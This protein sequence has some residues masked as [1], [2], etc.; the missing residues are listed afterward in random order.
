M[1][2]PI[3]QVDAF[4]EQAFEG[5][6]AAVVLL[7][8][9]AGAAWMQAVAAEMNLSETAFVLPEGPMP[10]SLRWF[11]PAAEV[12]LCGHATLATA[13]MLYE[14]GRIEQDETLRFDSVSGELRARRLSDGRIELDFPQTPAAPC[15]TPPSLAAALGVEPVCVLE[16]DWCHLAELPSAEAVRQLRP[17]I[18]ALGG[19]GKG[20]WIVTAAGEPGGKFDFISR[21]FGPGVGVD[22]DPVTGAA[23]T[24]LGPYWRA[25]LGKTDM[26]ARQES[27]RG[28]TVGVRLDGGR[29]FLAGHAVTI[30]AGQLTNLAGHA[31]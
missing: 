29:V 26:L 3:F 13:H 15:P 9:P 8:A 30:F 22:E 20:E 19:L 25:K 17:D 27:P 1:T 7:D 16:A 14:L 2:Q 24:V 12:P 10:W 6:P 28:G 21:F 18:R 23:H 5:N 11:T 31:G 4:A